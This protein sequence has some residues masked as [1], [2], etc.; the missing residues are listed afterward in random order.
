MDILETLWQ[1]YRTGGYDAVR[2][3]ALPPTPKNALAHFYV[4]LLAFGADDL[5]QAIRWAQTAAAVSEPASRV[6]T[7]AV[8]YLQ[9]V[10][11]QGKAHVYVDGDA[12]A[13]FIR[14]GGNVALYAAASAA[15]RK[16]YAGYEALRL[17]D[18]GVGDGLAL[19][20]A[21][22]DNLAQLTLVEPSEPMLR[23][24]AQALSSRGVNFEAHNTTM[25]AFI[26]GAVG[27]NRHWDIIQATWSLQSFPPDERPP[28]LDWMHTHGRR[29]L[30]VEF[31]VPAFSAMFAPERVRY[32][33]ER[34]ERGLAEYDHDQGL[35]ARGFL[36]PVMFGYFDRSAARTNW[37]GPIQGWADALREAGFSRVSVHKLYAYFWA[38]AY[39]VDARR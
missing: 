2:E 7:H 38:D 20:P 21:L 30:V 16:R 8:H 24:T 11:A 23:R 33:V 34:Y 19:L 14:G 36:M 37:E 26:A 4:A 29:A 6:F 35:V 13:A 15:L 39:L 27:Q 1:R 28:V 17:L 31:D 10:Y 25:Q 22:L 32:V 12:F 3:T 9:R 5:S 18:I